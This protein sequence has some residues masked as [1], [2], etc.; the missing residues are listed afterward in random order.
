MRVHINN[1]RIDGG[2]D[3]FIPV[4]PVQP[5][6]L[7]DSFELERFTV[8]EN[9]AKP[10]AKVEVGWRIVPKNGNANF[11]D[12]DFQLIGP[13]YL[14]EEITPSQGEYKFPVLK[15]TTLQI[16]GRKSQGPWQSL[17][18]HIDLQIDKSECINASVPL[19]VIN[20]KVFEG[21]GEFLSDTAELRYR[22]S[23]VTNPEN[24]AGPKIRVKRKPR[25][26]WT[27]QA[28][29][30]SFPFEI[31][32]PDY[33]NIDLDIEA[34]IRFSLTHNAD[35]AD[36]DV[37][38]EFTKIQV[39]TQDIIDNIIHPLGPLSVGKAIEKLLPLVVECRREPIE[40]AV[41]NGLLSFWS[42]PLGDDG[43]FFT[44]TIDPGD[45][46]VTGYLIADICAPEPEEPVFV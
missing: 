39:N 42:I 29:K 27:Y 10:F 41:I 18:N 35:G 5:L 13:P 37:T 32:I 11:D 23:L 44:I 40:R 24:P 15:A 20:V 30:Y 16:R 36:L 2:G 43:Q 1:S 8:D 26:Q 12:Y 19:S 7:N 33:F 22:S 3:V 38:L 4:D 45:G 34:E 31:V 46:E 25:F 14:I 6:D 21:V 9:P 28:L 17:G